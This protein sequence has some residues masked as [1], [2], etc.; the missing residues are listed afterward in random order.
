MYWLKTLEATLKGLTD[1]PTRKTWKNVGDEPMK[2]VLAFLFTIVI[3][4]GLTSGPAQGTAIDFAGPSGGTIS[5]A[6]G[7]A[8]LLG[9]DLPI[10]QV[11]VIP[12]GGS[13]AVSVT[14]GLL[15]FGT[16][17]F[18]SAIDLP[19]DSFVSFFAAGGSLTI[20]GGVPTAGIADGSTL[21]SATFNS[22][23]IFNYN[24]Y[25]IASLSGSLSVSFIDSSLAAYFG[26]E[27]FAGVGSLAQVDLSI[28][29]TGGTAGPGVA[30]SGQQGSV[31][32]IATNPEPTT[33]LLLGSGLAGIGI[34]GRRR[35]KGTKR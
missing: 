32:I 18:S 17:A 35:L 12:L 5:Y 13:S 3:L 11:F 31:N 29:F 16:G 23:P 22:S 21:L 33:L 27:P 25:G 2:T 1:R 34:W 4:L 7:S 30:F 19:G 24:G 6:G 26:I 10:N 14:G 20:T 8:P 15:N 28:E 9:I